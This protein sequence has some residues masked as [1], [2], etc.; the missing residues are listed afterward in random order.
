MAFLAVLN[1]YR[2]CT[3]A[4]NM[5][6]MKYICTFLLVFVMS[7]AF[8]QNEIPATESGKRVNSAQE[9]LSK[10]K[11]SPFGGINAKNIGP[12]VMSGR[13]VDLKVNP[14]DHHIFYVAYASGGLWK[15]INNGASFEPLFDQEMVMTI[16]AFDINWETNE[17][18][19]GTGEVNSSRSSYAGV[20]MFHSSDDGETWSF[21]GLEDS[22]HIGRVI[23]HPTSPETVYV[24]ALGH[25]YSDN[26]ERGLFKTTNSGESWEK[27]LSISEKTGIVECIM[28]PK[29][30]ETLYASS[31]Q[32]TRRAWDFTESGLESSIYKTTDGGKT[33]SNLLDNKN[34]FPHTEGTGRIGLSMAYQ[35]D[36][37][38]LYALVDNYD[39]R[40][41]EEKESKTDQITKDQ[42]K[43][44]SK[45]DF[46]K[47]DSDKV[48]KYLRSN[49]FPERYT[50]EGVTEDIKTGK[51]KVADLATYL[52]DANRLLFD[53]PV[54]GAELYISNDQG[55]TWAK[56]HD[57]YLDRVYNSYGYYFGLV[58]A[59]PSNPE[60]VYIAG[61]PILRSDDGGKTFENMNKANVHADHHAL[62]VNPKNHLH[63]INGNDGGINISYD[64]GENWFKCNNP[65]VGQF[66]AIQ[67][68]NAEPYNVFGGL[69]DNGVWYGSN[70]YEESIRW[71]QSGQYPYKSIMGGDGM[72]IAVDTRTNETVYTGFQF[73]NYYR[74][75]LNTGE[76]KYVTPSHELG[77]SP[78][79]WNWQT[80]VGL[81]SHNRDILYMGA[82]KLMRSMNQGNEFVAI[83]DDL[84]RGGRKGD[85]A[86][87]TLT[88]FSESPLK[89]GLIYTGS[90]DGMVYRTDD[91]GATWIDITDGLPGEFWVSRIQASS[92]DLDRVFVTLNGYRWDN[93]ESMTYVSDN[94][95]KTW[96]KIGLDLPLEP[97]NVILE[98]PMFETLLYVGTD[99]GTYISTDA[100]A[101]FNILSNSIPLV[102]VHDLVIQEREKDL[103]V[104]THG[105]SI[106]Q[107]DLEPIYSVQGRSEELVVQNELKGRVR[108]SWGNKNWLRKF[109]EP[110]SKLYVYHPEGATLDVT[111]KAEDGTI[112][113]KDSWEVK[114]GFQDYG[115]DYTWDKEMEKAFRKSLDQKEKFE[116]KENGQY[117]LVEGKYTLEFSDGKQTAI[118]SIELK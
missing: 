21:K 114:A 103:L 94:R 20:G 60:V 70:Q 35:G 19:L 84:T 12:T 63:L 40:E 1:S 88:S 108:D 37:S 118:T 117:Y 11:M 26:Q 97:V 50:S 17:I 95:G 10:A 107:L 13:V 75:N 31:W 25:L 39:R 115:F 78:Y 14:K 30:P 112:I 68:D 100:G 43:S 29:D 42:L 2:I 74:I 51:V 41:P 87:G 86:Y 48:E 46:L 98:D 83:S 93:F 56:T 67:V 33:W 77:D 58:Q 32:R 3:F 8:A 113:R 18:W 64:G 110:E 105:R 90:D 24:A 49:Y 116:A 101:S 73:G 16:G 53:T 91:G 59:A 44:M 82:N 99:H 52:E 80:P 81:S 69:Q 79:R 54:K 36:Q 4:R 55:Q 15:T 57:E 76:R 61:V 45:E 27:V 106:Y 66:Y 34:G 47:L 102:A 85:V 104:G 7:G 5:N 23:I 28:D 71:H 92:H 9:K 62:W 72:Q 96:R 22:H 38:L 65:S 89:F 111:L 109:N 6:F